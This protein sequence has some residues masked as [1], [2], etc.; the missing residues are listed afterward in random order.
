MRL[1]YFDM[2]KG[3]AIFMVVMGH[4][5]TACIRGIDSAVC[6]K[7]IGLVHMPMFFFISGFFT[8]RTDGE[9]RLRA[10]DLVRRGLQLLVPMVFMS[11]LWIYYFPHSGLKSP[12]D[13]TWSGLWGD[14]WKN[15]YWFT[16]TLFI[17][18]VIYRLLVVVMNRWRGGW[19]RAAAAVAV[20][21]GLGVAAR[22]VPAGVADAVEL[23]FVFKYFIVFMAGVWASV[24]RERFIAMTQSSGWFTGAVL[25]GACAAYY[26]MYPWDFVEL[27]GEVRD[28]C[29]IVIHLCLAIIGVAV[30]K[31]WSDRQWAEGH[32]PSVAARMW[33]TLGRNSLGIY[34]I[35]YFLLFP[36]TGMQ[37]VMR[38]FNLDFVPTFVV[39]AGTAAAIVAVT[40][41]II[42]VVKHSRLLSLLML[43]VTGK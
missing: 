16:L 27:P 24:E 20:A 28:Y 33:A 2:L 29:Q 7:L 31:P 6:F 32:R 38:S 37:G 40:M 14:L 34:L 21:V 3:I 26:V 11:S 42:E 15:G 5:L 1:H 12:F 19:Q 23:P 25:V 9:G 30:V 17:I 18:I 35:H 10:P 22:F 43:G 39:A 4:V 13:S 36:M 8:G 41:G